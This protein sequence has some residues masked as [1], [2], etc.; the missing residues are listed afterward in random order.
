MQHAFFTKLVTYG[1]VVL[2]L[3]GCASFGPEM[4]GLGRSALLVRDR[5]KEGIVVYRATGGDRDIESMVLNMAGQGQVDM[6]VR[7]H[8][9]SLVYGLG[10]SYGEG[11]IASE[12]RE[13][14]IEYR[15]RDLNFLN[16][17][18]VHVRIP[19]ETAND[20][21]KSER[22]LLT[23]REKEPATDPAHPDLSAP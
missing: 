2:C 12:T 19:R 3:A 6:T 11:A 8:D 15:I 9:L 17:G 4:E 10:L 20:M 22:I 13:A 21:V 18:E 5:R 14:K 7:Y 16:P 1:S 23:V